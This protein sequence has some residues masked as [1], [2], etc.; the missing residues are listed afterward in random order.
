MQ[1]DGLFPGIETEA[2]VGPGEE[3]AQLLFAD[4]PLLTQ[5]GEKR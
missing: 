1:S 5:Q 2:A 4:N 3:L